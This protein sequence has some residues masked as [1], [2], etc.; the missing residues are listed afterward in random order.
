M[1][2]RRNPLSA[3]VE[4]I[5]TGASWVSVLGLWAVAA[6]VYVSPA[7]I[8]IAGVIGLAF[9]MLLVGTLLCL[10]FCLLFAPRRSW[11]PLVGLLFS[12]GSIRSYCPFNFT[13]DEPADL[14]VMTYNC[15]GFPGVTT[16]EPKR[17][18]LEY[19]ESQDADIFV[20]QEGNNSVPNWLDLYP[21]FAN[22]FPY[23]EEPYEGHTTRQGLYSRYPIQRTELVTASDMNAVVAFWLKLPKGD[24]LLVVNCHLKTNNL[25]PED[26]TQY[27]RIVKAAKGGNNTEDENAK[28]FTDPDST[29]TT[30]RTLAGKIATSAAI[31]ATMVDTIADFLGRHKDIRT[32]VC[33]DFNDTPIS[34][35]TH[36]MKSLG[37]NDAYRMAGNGMGRSFNKDAIAVRIDHQFCSDHYRPISA[38]VDKLP[39]W[40]D[41]YPLIV[42]YKELQPPSNSPR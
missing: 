31:R 13:S 15:H 3:F 38:F 34:Y 23:Y 29:F 10:F 4:A 28:P 36:R 30:S 25:T 9:P 27:S 19:I 16:D 35:S 22:R 5:L 7:D 21:A 26:R 20:Y 6:S 41:H 37:L 14:T 32:I 17:Q 40:S 33:G 2:Y 24:S 11:I 1:K 42:K 8:R 12:A 39:Q 18:I